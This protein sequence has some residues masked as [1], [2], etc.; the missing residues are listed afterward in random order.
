MNK[1]LFEIYDELSTELDRFYSIKFKTEEDEYNENKRIKLAIIDFIVEAKKSNQS[2]YIGKG[3][4]LLFD[5]TGCQEDY[6]ILNE[7]IA[8]L[9]EDNILSP[10]LIGKYLQDSPLSRWL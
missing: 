8:P 3:L 1:P 4:E 6:E 2:I 9:F 7:I 5:N 10:E